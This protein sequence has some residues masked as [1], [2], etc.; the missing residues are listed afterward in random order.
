[1]ETWITKVIIIFIMLFISLLFG[2]VPIKVVGRLKLNGHRAR[3]KTQ[4]IISLLNCFAGGVFL[5]TTFLHLFPEVKEGMEALLKEEGV[6]TPF[7]ITEF[8]ITGGMFVIMFIEHLVMT[9]QHHQGDVS[10]PSSTE[11]SYEE[12]QPLCHSHKDDE[13]QAQAIIKTNL[14]NYGSVSND[15]KVLYRNRATTDEQCEALIRPNK[16]HCG[17]IDKITEDNEDQFNQVNNSVDNGTE[18]CEDRNYQVRGC[19][20]GQGH[21]KHKRRDVVCA[22]HRDVILEEG[23][24]VHVIRPSHH[25]HHHIE[26]QQLGGIRSFLLLLAMSL[27]TVFEGL[28]IGLQPNNTSVWSLF[29]AVIIHKCVIAFSLGIQF[30]ENIQHTAR[31]VLFIVFFAV[32]SPV[33]AAIGTAMTETGSGSGAVDIASAI[34]QGLSAGVFLY[35]TF[36]EVLGKEVGSDHSLI[37]VSLIIFGYGVIAVIQLLLPEPEDEG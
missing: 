25:Q 36:F 35:V 32:M 13:N 29:L 6:D 27:H 16:E 30:A 12:Q 1:M 4:R 3:P 37:K 15:A 24:C 18:Q 22:S 23:A 34:L 17:S 5:A 20:Q 33:G 14:R 21:S 10:F 28:A 26:P 31:A 7:P 11:N 2:L 9:I 8:T 19:T